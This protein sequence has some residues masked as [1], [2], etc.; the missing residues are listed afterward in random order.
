MKKDKIN[1]LV[2]G[3]AGFIGSHIVDALMK[4]ERVGLVRVLDCDAN[5]AERNLSHYL[6]EDNKMRT[7]EKLHFILGDIR[8][9]S[10]MLEVCAGI[11][12]ICHQAADLSDFPKCYDTNVVGTN[13]LLRCAEANGVKR[14]VFASSAAVYGEI[15][16]GYFSKEDDKLSPVNHYGVSKKAMEVLFE[17]TS[18]E[19]IGLRYFNVYGPRQRKG[20]IYEMR[21]S[22]MLNKRIEIF[23]EGNQERDFISWKSVVGLNVEAI[24]SDIN[25]EIYNAST[26]NIHSISDIARLV[27]EELYTYVQIF[28]I[29]Q[30][31]GVERSAAERI[32]LIRNQNFHS[33]AFDEFS[34]DFKETLEW[35]KEDVF[36]NK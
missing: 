27:S 15:P 28:N 20:V 16:E 4:D 10:F 19:W 11:D 14:I 26:F 5:N 8:I 35:I 7:V 33:Y 36:K 17:G 31:I 30:K 3:G 32:K 29:P 2:T 25:R 22:A 34:K 23:G 1:V 24:F 12:V 18:L 9:D 6:L 13:V 21:K